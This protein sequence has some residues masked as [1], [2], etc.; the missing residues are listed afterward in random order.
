MRDIKSEVIADIKLFS[1]QEANPKTFPLCPPLYECPLYYNEQY[2][3]CQLILDAFE[4]PIELG[5]SFEAPIKFLWPQAIVPRL[6]YGDTFCLWENGVIGAGKIIATTNRGPVYDNIKLKFTP[7]DLKLYD[8]LCNRFAELSSGK[9]NITL[10][11][12]LELPGSLVNTLEEIHALREK[13]NVIVKGQPFYYIWVLDPNESPLKK[14]CEK[15]K[16]EKC[17][18]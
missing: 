16:L 3:D 14:A 11:R 8:K 18:G 9:N 6:K 2:Y 12:E 10:W 17:W 4:D 5:A 15:Q 13:Y 7:S 1:R